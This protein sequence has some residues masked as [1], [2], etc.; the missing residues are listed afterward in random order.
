[1][2]RGYV[3]ARARTCEE[4]CAPAECAVA[5]LPPQ[6]NLTP[7]LAPSAGSTSVSPLP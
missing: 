5:V 4:E 3:R 2:E 1:M 6:P 7:H